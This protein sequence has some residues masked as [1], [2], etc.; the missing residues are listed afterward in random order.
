MPIFAIS[1]MA[2]LSLVGGTIALGM[3]SRSSNNLQHAADS[4]A[5]GGATAFLHSDSPKAEERLKA[6]HEQARSL[7]TQNTDYSLTELD[8]AAVTEDAYGQHTNLKVELQ[9][10]PVNYFAKLVGSK[11][12]TPIRRRAVATATWGFPLCVLTLEPKRSGLTIKDQGQLEANNCI[13]WSN[14]DSRK[15]MDFKGGSAKTKAFCAVGDVDKDSRAQVDPKPEVGCQPLPDPLAGYEVPT[16]G[17]CDSFSVD[18]IRIGSTKLSPGIYCGGLSVR[19]RNVT[20]EPGIYHIRGGGL[21]IDARGELEAHGVTFLFDGLINKVEIRG[22]SGLKVTAPTEGETAGM[23]FA[24]L[25]SVVT[26]LPD[27]KIDGALNVEGV[28]YMPSYDI[29]IKKLGGGTTRSPYLQ[30]VANSL[31]ISDQGSLA[32]EFD[33]TQTDLPLVIKPAREARLV[34]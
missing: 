20:L 31:E 5:L 30:I 22:G 19:A 18:V 13:I 28:I 26:R 27:M 15:A 29:K 33:M 21:K 32:I 4:S 24:Q 16:S 11:S 3:D 34:E 9:F 10:K 7:A 25:P 17:I 1:L 6:A 8:V 23:A 12:T 2:I 14:S